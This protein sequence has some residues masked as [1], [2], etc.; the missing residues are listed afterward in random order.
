MLLQQIGE[1]GQRSLAS[2][3]V[4]VAGC[5]A[6]G[7]VA[8]DLFTRAGVGTVVIV[9][10]D[11]VELTNLQRQTLFT[12]RDA[13][14]G[15]PKAEAAKARLAQIN[16]DVRVRAFV[17]DIAAD[18][19]VELASECDVLVDGLDNFQTRYLLNDYAVSEGVPYIYGAAVATTGMS[20]PILP[21]GGG[22]RRVRW[23]DDESTPCLQCMFP[24]PPPAGASATCDTAGVLGSVTMTIAAHV[25]TQTIKLLCDSISSVDRSLLSI[26]VWSNQFKRLQIDHALNPNCPCCSQRKFDSLH[27]EVGDGL[28]ILCGR[29]AVQV[30]P[31]TRQNLDLETMQS[32]LTAHGVFQKRDGALRGVLEHE[33]SPDSCPVELTLFSDGRAIVAGSTDPSWARGVYDRFIGQ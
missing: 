21:I 1:Q 3:T 8:A 33:Q 11:V 20:M 6:L 22:T 18:T 32:R 10:R 26:D 23:Q 12:E 19:I 24:E 15:I 16:S 9:D 28:T 29:N 5:G 30:R 14:R 31:S 25:V 27:G 2:S 4:L 17:E 7:T 13:Q